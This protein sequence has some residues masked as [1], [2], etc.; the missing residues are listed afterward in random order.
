[1][2]SAVVEGVERRQTAEDPHES[3]L[4]QALLLQQVR[5]GCGEREGEE[6]VAEQVH[7]DVHGQDRCSCTSLQARSPETKREARRAR[8]RASGATK[9]P[10]TS[11]R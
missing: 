7:R 1:M 6:G 3:L 9:A 8:V 5:D 10:T 2:R 11:I 4:L